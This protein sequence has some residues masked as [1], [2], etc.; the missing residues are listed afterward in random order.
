MFLW[1][2]ERVESLSFERR[3]SPI[4]KLGGQQASIEQAGSITCARL[5]ADTYRRPE[6]I[7][8]CTLRLVTACTADR[9]IAAKTSI[10]EQALAKFDFRSSDGVIRGRKN[11]WQPETVRIVIPNG[12][13]GEN[14]PAGDADFFEIGSGFHLRSCISACVGTLREKYVH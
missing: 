14:Y 6:S 2:S 9:A 10:E 13:R 3:A 11:W 7:A 5:P 1:I 4:P 8:E 12:S